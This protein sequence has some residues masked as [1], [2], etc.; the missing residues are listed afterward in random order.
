M[1]GW[2]GE[3]GGGE[4]EGNREGEKGGGLGI[5]DRGGPWTKDRGPALGRDEQ[6]LR[7]AAGS[8]QIGSW[9]DREAAGQAA[10]LI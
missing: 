9:P 7:P 2:L 3:G 6:T 5:E 10:W 4:G 8:R 1:S